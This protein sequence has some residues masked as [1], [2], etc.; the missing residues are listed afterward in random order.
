MDAIIAELASEHAREAAL[1]WSLL[2]AGAEDAADE[3]ALRARIAAHRHGMRVCVARGA[4]PLSGLDRPWRGAD[5]LAVAW[6]RPGVQADPDDATGQ[7]AKTA[8]LEW[9]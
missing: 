6:M 1:L 5:L 2:D 8:A 9:P 3:A 4:D 7:R